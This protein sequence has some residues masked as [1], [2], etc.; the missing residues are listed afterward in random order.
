MQGIKCQP[1][2]QKPFEGGGGKIIFSKGTDT[3]DSI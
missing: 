1:K 2:S 3:L